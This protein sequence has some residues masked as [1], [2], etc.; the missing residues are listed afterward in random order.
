VQVLAEK[1]VAGFQAAV[2]RADSADDL[3]RWLKDHGYAFSPEVQ[4]WAQPYVQA[5]TRAR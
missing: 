2:L 1:L 3:V 5:E 4:A